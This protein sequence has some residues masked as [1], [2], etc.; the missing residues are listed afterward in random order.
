MQLRTL[1]GLAVVL[2]GA[3]RLE[4]AGHGLALRTRS[5]AV[6]TKRRYRTQ[7]QL[8]HDYVMSAWPCVCCCGAR[9]GG[10][11]KPCGD[12]VRHSWRQPHLGVQVVLVAQLVSALAGLRAARWN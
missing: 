9:P 12:N 5:R 8:L 2:V 4:G 7:E 10:A 6:P 3:R 11:L 1:V